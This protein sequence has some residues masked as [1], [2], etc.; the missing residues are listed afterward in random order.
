[1]ITIVP[2]ALYLWNSILKEYFNQVVELLS[3]IPI[4]SAYQSFILLLPW[5]YHCNVPNALCLSEVLQ[6][7]PYLV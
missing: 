1:M 4:I 6:K 2:D 5:Y 7:R 3:S